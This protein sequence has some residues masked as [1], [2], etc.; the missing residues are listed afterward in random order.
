[1]FLETVLLQ[2]ALTVTQRRDCHPYPIFLQITMHS[3]NSS[4]Q[5]AGDG[6]GSISAGSGSQEDVEMNFLAKIS[7]ARTLTNILQGIHLKKD[8]VRVLPL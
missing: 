1:M 6:V 2:G 5:N 8:Q 3:V 7:N 4:A